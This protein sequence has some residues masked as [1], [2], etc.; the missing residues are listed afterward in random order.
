ML[1][2]PV[3]MAYGWRWAFVIPSIL[4]LLWL[5]PWLMTYR[6]QARRKA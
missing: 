1:I 5:V 2:V 3:G 6:D 4:G